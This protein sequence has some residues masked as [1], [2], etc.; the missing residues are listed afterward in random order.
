[1]DVVERRDGGRLGR[2]LPLMFRQLGGA[3]V[4]VA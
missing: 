2:F 1:V 4:E 3:V